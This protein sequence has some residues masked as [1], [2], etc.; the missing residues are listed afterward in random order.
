ML[1]PSLP[2]T[3]PPPLTRQMTWWILILPATMVAALWSRNLY[4]LDWTHILSASLWTGADLFL[5]FVLSTVLRR[6]SPAERK[7][8]IQF[9]VPRTL[10]YLPIAALTTSTAGWYLANW[11]GFLAPGNANRPW[12]FAALAITTILTVQGLGVLLPN[13]VRI[14]RELQR[15]NP[16]PDRIWKIN[17]VNL[18][19]AG[20]QGVLQLIILLVMAHLVMG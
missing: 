4:L 13:Q 10:L 11:L 6:L 8:V 3:A 16:D 14:W 9:L 2:A 20:V 1:E 19:L 15:P 18:R 5:G 17:R 12:I 7:A